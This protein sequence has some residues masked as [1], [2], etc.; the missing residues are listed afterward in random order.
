[1]L[2]VPPSSPGELEDS[3][4]P[5]A[6]QAIG[7]VD[8]HS[9]LLPGV[10]D[11]C[12]DVSESLECA[13]RLADAG[14]THVFC[15]PHV[16]PDLPHNNRASLGPAV[17]QLQ[18][19]LDE[20]R[21]AL[22]LY[23]GG[24]MRL[25]P[26]MLE[27]PP[28]DLLL[29]NLGNSRGGK[30]LLFDTWESEWPAYFQKVMFRFMQLG[31]IPIMAHPERCAFVHDDPLN[32]ADRLADLGVLLQLNCY[33]LGDEKAM[34]KG[35]FSKPM[36]QAAERLIEFDYYSF[37]A[38]DVHRADTMDDR[39]SALDTARNYMG[40]AMFRKLAKRNPLQILPP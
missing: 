1:M 29:L 34:K 10:D 2:R 7:L 31:I 23:P 12:R 4:T 9:H 21:I 22:T 27:T 19:A 13:R 40:S 16:A 14:F 26:A 33:V 39:L 11:G 20:A 3:T 17:A 24:E 35:L 18:A 8:I 36:R 32:V 5:P 38:S 37:L 28:E 6:P 15:T 25:G 30:F